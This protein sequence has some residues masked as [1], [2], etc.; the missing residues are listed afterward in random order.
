MQG[1]KE[2]LTKYV[3]R[4]QTEEIEK[5]LLCKSTKN[6]V[7]T[8]SFSTDQLLYSLYI[9]PSLTIY[10]KTDY[11]CHILSV[12]SVSIK[13][14]SSHIPWSHLKMIRNYI[15][16]SYVSVIYKCFMV[17]MET[18]KDPY[19]AISCYI[20]RQVLFH[21]VFAYNFPIEDT[22]PLEFPIILTLLITS[23]WW[24]SPELA[25]N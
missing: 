7:I 20:L 24:L 10:F 6:S 13:D 8:V 9:L 5:T 22:G 12:L 23:F 1:E 15:E 3:R 16:C 21:F 2:Y 17:W 11:N 25:T 18:Q 4:N 14:F 19:A